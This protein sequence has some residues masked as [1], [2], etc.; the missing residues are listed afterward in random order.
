MTDGFGDDPEMTDGFCPS[1]S[2]KEA[3][4]TPSP[5]MTGRL[6]PHQG[7]MTLLRR[8]PHLWKKSLLKFLRTRQLKSLEERAT[9]G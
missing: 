7:Q 2:K 9:D 5:K 4:E 1:G 6:F 3:V 8:P